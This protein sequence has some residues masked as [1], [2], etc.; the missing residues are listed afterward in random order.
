MTPQQRVWT[1]L[2][3]VDDHTWAFK[4]HIQTWRREEEDGV[5]TVR[6]RLARPPLATAVQNNKTKQ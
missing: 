6:R 4:P 3:K 5:Y 2:D 1:I